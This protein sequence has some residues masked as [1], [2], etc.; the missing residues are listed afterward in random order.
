MVS[1]HVDSPV[2]PECPRRS[3]EERGRDA[4]EAVL[5]PV[6]RLVSSEQPHRDRLMAADDPE[7]ELQARIVPDAADV[8]LVILHGG[9]APRERAVVLL[10]PVEAPDPPP[11]SSHADRTE[12]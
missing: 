11:P 2:S 10:R 4:F 9:D 12:D 8:H 6:N 3:P 1:G 7:W 5:E